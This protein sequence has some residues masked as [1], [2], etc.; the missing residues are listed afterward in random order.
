MRARARVLGLELVDEQVAGAQPQCAFRCGLSGT[1]SA[2]TLLGTVGARQPGI[3][4]GMDVVTCRARRQVQVCV[5]CRAPRSVWTLSALRTDGAAGA[6]DPD[7]VVA[8]VGPGGRTFR[9]DAST[10]C[11]DRHSGGSASAGL[12]LSVEPR[13]AK[14]CQRQ[15]QGDESARQPGGEH[16][17]EEQAVGL[18]GG[19]QSEH[20]QDDGTKVKQTAN[21]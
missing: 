15:R 18:Q 7:N 20:K 16:L 21:I 9:A 17:R 3:H 1:R 8:I 10:H 4:P 13:D 11:E 19:V 14:A 2:G 12:E 6:I 5:G